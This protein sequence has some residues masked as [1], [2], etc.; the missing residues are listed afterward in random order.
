MSKRSLIFL[1]AL[2]V[3][4]AAL[5]YVYA[6]Q[7]GGGDFVFNGFLLN[8]LDGNSYLAKM[9]E[10]WL[11]SW[12]FSMLYSSQA[13]QGSYLFLL[14]IALGHL[15]RWLGLPLLLVFHGARIVGVI[16]LCLAL[17]RFIEIYLADHSGRTRTIAFVLLCLGSGFGWLAAL[18][19]GFTSDFWVAEAYP[20]LS[21]YSNPH[22]PLGLALLLDF[23]ILLRQPH[24]HK[25]DLWLA[26]KGLLLATLTPFGIVVA[27]VTAGG[28]QL[29]ELIKQERRIRWWMLYFF[30]PGGLML[31]YQVI[32]IRSD[33]VLAAWN[34]QNLTITPPL[35]DFV[36]SFSPA[37][38][39]AAVTITLLIQRNKLES[40]KLLAVWLIGGLV[41]A[42]VPFQ[43]QR[44][45]IFGYFIPAACLAAI[46]LDWAL[47]NPK[48]TLRIGAGIL[49]GFSFLTNLLV[50]SGGMLAAG[51]RSPDLYYSRNLQGVF[52]WMLVN[53]KSCTVVLAAPKIGSILPGATGWRVVYG[54]P[55]ETPNAAEMQAQVERLFSGKMSQVEIQANLETLGVDFV[56]AGPAETSSSAD[57]GWL[58][59]FPKIT[60]SGDVSLYQVRDCP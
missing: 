42:Y 9:R 53:K 25:F 24:S 21:M 1:T 8:P 26:V 32:V 10:G 35:W 29:W 51:Q 31:L 13:P 39:L 3:L 7:R 34:A 11:G 12:Q 30:V 22:F 38:L 56:L 4:L 2:T 58:L 41:L 44:R 5:P 6:A 49:L 46:T 48:R 57:L 40:Y 14:Y 19:G 59:D 15:A 20:F 60:S 43:L 16:A 27:A 23:F 50:V 36:V 33:P 54:H 52:D 18:F 17:Y 47:T 45:F 28:V 37:F 55:Y